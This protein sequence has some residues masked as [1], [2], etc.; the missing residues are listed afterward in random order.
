MAATID[1]GST[2]LTA[3][4][5]ATMESIVDLGVTEGAI[6]DVHGDGLALDVDQAADLGVGLGDPVTVGFSATGDVELTVRA[7][8][9]SDLLG[10]GAWTT[11]WTSTPSRPT[12]PTCSTGRC[13]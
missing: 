5:T 6:E 8:Y 10:P 13:T 3:F 9:D 7:L 11:S 2:E 1:G 4:D 12:S